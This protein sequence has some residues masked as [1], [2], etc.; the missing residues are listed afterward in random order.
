MNEEIE[1]RRYYLEM[2]DANIASICLVMNEMA[3]YSAEEA[4][5]TIVVG[6][7]ELAADAAYKAVALDDLMRPAGAIKHGAAIGDGLAVITLSYRCTSTHNHTCPTAARKA[8]PA[9]ILGLL[10]AE[11]YLPMDHYH[12]VMAH[13]NAM[14]DMRWGSTGG[15]AQ[16][17]TAQAWH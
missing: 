12:R 6:L 15:K 5:F 7:K 8:P 10:A 16:M 9:F 1:T 17:H 11:E 14:E 4:D 13:L 2:D 3:G